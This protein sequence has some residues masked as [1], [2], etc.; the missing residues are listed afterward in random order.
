MTLKKCFI[1]LLSRS[2]G[3]LVLDLLE[4][5]SD[6]YGASGDPNVVQATSRLREIAASCRNDDIA[7][8]PSFA[9]L[10]DALQHCTAGP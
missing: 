3:F 6:D 8:L 1:K 7:H 2:F 4:W 10:V 5:L 9:A